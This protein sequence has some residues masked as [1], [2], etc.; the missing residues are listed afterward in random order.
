MSV[1]CIEYINSSNI[2]LLSTYYVPQALCNILEIQQWKNEEMHE[3][4]SQRGLSSGP[5]S[6]QAI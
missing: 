1:E 4:G 6:A 3:W 5:L 2:Y